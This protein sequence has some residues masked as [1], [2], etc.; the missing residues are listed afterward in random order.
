MFP[1]EIYVLISQKISWKIFREVCKEFN[2]IV[3]E[4]N[5]KINRCNHLLTLMNLHPDKDWN[6]KGLS[7]N[8]NITWEIVKDNPDKDWSFGCLSQN[9]NITWKI[10]KNNPDKKWNFANLSILYLNV[11]KN[12]DILDIKILSFG[13]YF[14]R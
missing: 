1:K 11:Y 7:Q 10:V 2:Q 4:Q 13:G 9:P 8:S 5:Y 3:E 14:Q 12:E 6:F